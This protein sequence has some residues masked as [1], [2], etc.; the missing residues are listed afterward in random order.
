MSKGVA[1]V[2][3]PAKAA[4][5]E[6]LRCPQCGYDLHGIPD[7]RCPECGFRYD[8]EA[9]RTLAAAEY[10]IRLNSSR[11]IMLH[12]TC[13]TALAIPHVCDHIGI[14]GWSRSGVSAAAFVVAFVTWIVVRDEYRGVVSIPNLMT[15]FAGTAL[16]FALAVQHAPGLVLIGSIVALGFAWMTRIANWAAMS[17]PG[18]PELTEIHREAT[19]RSRAA[20]A[21]L[22][23]AS[24]VCLFARVG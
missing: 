8:A 15:L 6:H 12:A 9:I 23:A 3:T 22:I 24:A 21:I 1:R 4:L 18:N 17:S 5:D 14:P 10:W 13:A 2:V 7:V 20:T 19:R 16:A 11:M